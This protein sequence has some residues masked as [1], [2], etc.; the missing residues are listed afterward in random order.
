MRFSPLIK[1]EENMKKFLSI[2]F[3]AFLVLGVIKTGLAAEGDTNF[4]N[5]VASGNVT[6]QSSLLA[7][8]RAG[9]ASTM[10]SSSTYLSTAGLA[11]SIIFKRVGGV[12]GLDS[13]GFGSVLP[14]GTPG[15]VITFYITALQGSGTW[16]LTPRTAMNWNKITFDTVGD[17]VTLMFIETIGWVIVS[18][19]GATVSITQI[20]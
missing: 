10:S 18:N 8:G 1:Q 4:T 7:N 13:N 6:F 12:G 14:D 9:G 3:S 5:V 17:N 15:Q 16:I 20:P 2:L 11:Y 19:S